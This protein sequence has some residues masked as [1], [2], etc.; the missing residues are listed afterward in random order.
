MVFSLRFKETPNTLDPPRA[1]KRSAV[2][3]DSN[4]AMFI[5]LAARRE[6]EAIKQPH[7][8]AIT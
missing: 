2:K 3:W 1:P 4:D 8:A 7:Q 6:E 5:G